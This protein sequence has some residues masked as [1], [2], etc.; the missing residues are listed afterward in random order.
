VTRLAPTIVSLALMGA[1]AA[2][3]AVA[4]RLKL[5]PSPVLGPVIERYFSPGCDCPTGGAE[6]RF[7]LAQRDVVS[8]TVLNSQG[9]PVRRLLTETPLHRGR[10]LLR[11]DG[12]ADDR[13]PVPQ[14][15]YRYRIEL[16]RKG[17]T[18]TL[19]FPVVADTTAPTVRIVS[20]EPVSLRAGTGG[21]AGRIKLRYRIDEHARLLV[22]FRG[23]VAVRGHLR[24]Q[25][26]G[27]LDWYARSGGRAL[28][29]GTY[30]IAVVA[31]D[32]AGNPSAP[33]Y[34]TVRIR[35]R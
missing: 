28:P 17:R 10:I 19:P 33:A 14:G 24:P 34:V 21:R 15:S 13:R 2:A 22:Y 12:K 6:L 16:Q 8:V 27:Q 7:R 26:R 3:F 18:V 23:R 9:Q 29:S 20:A 32:R 35:P 1:S 31:R 25:L 11:W 30:R 4:E 5:Q